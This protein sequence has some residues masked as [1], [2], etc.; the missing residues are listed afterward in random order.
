MTANDNW[1]NQTAVRWIPRGHPL[2]LDTWKTGGSSSPHTQTTLCSPDK[3]CSLRFLA[4]SSQATFRFVTCPVTLPRSP[5]TQTASL[6]QVREQGSRESRKLPRL[7]SCSLLMPKV[8]LSPPHYLRGIEFKFFPTRQQP[9]I[10][11]P[12]KL[13]IITTFTV[14]WQGARLWVFSRSNPIK[15]V[16]HHPHVIGEETEEENTRQ[17]RIFSMVTG[18]SV[19]FFKFSKVSLALVANIIKT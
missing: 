17:P 4:L 2:S 7:H 14:H 10:L 13:E 19:F 16:P 11:F 5:A 8:M 6:P 15:S 12:L 18:Y 3:Y 9:I 1:P